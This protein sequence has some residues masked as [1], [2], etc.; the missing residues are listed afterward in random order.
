MHNK[1]SLQFQSWKEHRILVALISS[2]ATLTP[3]KMDYKLY[4]Q[5]LDIKSLK[6]A[7]NTVSERPFETICKGKF[8][9][10]L[11]IH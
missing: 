6:K 5:N 7:Q 3:P 4:S 11:E 10:M 1:I 9:R 2:V 8:N